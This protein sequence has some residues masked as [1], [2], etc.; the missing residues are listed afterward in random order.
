MCLCVF[1]AANA[2]VADTE[3]NRSE[4]DADAHADA[5]ADADTH[6]S[7]LSNSK[8]VDMQG[9]FDILIAANLPELAVP[10]V[11]HMFDI[12]HGGSI[13]MREFM[14]TLLAL[15]PPVTTTENV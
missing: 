13:S 3:T 9:F 4:D 7:V 10:S 1:L 5:H 11:F 8:D 2:D 14:F 12:D 15:R 6:A